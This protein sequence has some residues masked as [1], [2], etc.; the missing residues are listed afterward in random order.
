MYESK[1]ETTTQA[2]TLPTQQ[3][4]TAV[5]QAGGSVLLSWQTVETASGYD[6]EYSQN[7]DFSESL[8]K[9]IS[10]FEQSEL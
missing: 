5:A 2:C 8:Q 9:N 6:I 4:I 10:D 7:D 3:E 1:K